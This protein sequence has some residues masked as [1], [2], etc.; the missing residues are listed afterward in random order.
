M[1]YQF[2]FQQSPIVE[3]TIAYQLLNE[4]VLDKLYGNLANTWFQEILQSDFRKFY[5]I[6]MREYDICCTIK[7]KILN[8]KYIGKPWTNHT[9]NS[10]IKRR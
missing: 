9:I 3:Q 10:Y 7:F 8:R 2:C 6:L 5:E 1:C 4:T